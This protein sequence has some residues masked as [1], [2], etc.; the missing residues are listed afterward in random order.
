MAAVRTDGY[1]RSYEEIEAGEEYKAIHLEDDE[2]HEQAALLS[3]KEYARDGSEAAPTPKASKC[4][5][6]DRARVTNVLSFFAGVLVCAVVQYFVCNSGSAGHT[7]SR[8]ETFA[9][10]EAGSTEVHRYPPVSPTNAFPSLFPTNIGY[11]GPTP[12]G[13]EAGLI[14]T[15]PA[16][17]IHT[18]APHLVSPLSF[19]SSH[20]SSETSHH[21]FDIF[22]HWGNLSPWFSVGQG[23]FGLDSSPE[24]PETCQITGLHFL[25]RHGARYPTSYGTQLSQIK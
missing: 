14:Q 3:P 11:A 4:C 5:A 16:Y 13:A 21:H 10:P 17:P 12:T 22:K 6:L 15:A 8:L 25:H 20:N 24:A 23:A 2:S 9:S 18:G 19:A 1:G 7:S